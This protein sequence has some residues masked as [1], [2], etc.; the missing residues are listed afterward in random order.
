VP[1]ALAVGLLMTPA[2]YH[3]MVEPRVVTAR[4]VVIV[5]S[6]LTLAMGPLAVG[7]ALE[8]FII[9]Y[10]ITASTVAAACVAFALLVALGALWYVFPS[11]MHK[12]GC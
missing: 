6:L 8:A 2:A 5:S 12:Q 1:V 7:S 11:L 9:S 3:R 4:F 10:T